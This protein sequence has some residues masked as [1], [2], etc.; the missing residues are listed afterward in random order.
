MTDRRI[1]PAQAKKERSLLDNDYATPCPEC[2]G[3]VFDWWDTET[4]RDCEDSEDE[5]GSQQTTLTDGGV[6]RPEHPVSHVVVLRGASKNRYHRDDGNGDP[7]CP[8][9]ERSDR[10]TPARSLWDIE[11]ADPRAVTLGHREGR[12]LA[13]TL[14]V[15]RLLRKPR[16]LE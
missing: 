15:R 11:K 6:D 12:R 4:C 16:R 14:P 5:T 1:G 13:R 8:V 9:L 3:V 10:D 7:A 2:G